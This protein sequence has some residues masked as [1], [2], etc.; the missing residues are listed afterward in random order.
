MCNTVLPK[1]QFNTVL[2]SRMIYFKVL[3]L[4]SSNFRYLVEFVINTHETYVK[5]LFLIGKF[6]VYRVKDVNSATLKII[7]MSNVKMTAI[8][9]VIF[10]CWLFTPNLHFFIKN[11]RNDE[12]IVG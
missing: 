5:P 8:L 2:G 3:K 1:L 10:R 11:L 7:D 4:K 9:V 6:D 12:M